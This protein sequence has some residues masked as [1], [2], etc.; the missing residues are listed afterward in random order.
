MLISYNWLKDYLG[1]DIPSVEEIT[2]LLTFH[3][4][5][6]DGVEDKGDDKVIDVKVLPDR[7]SDSLSHRGVAREIAT[8]IDESLVLDLFKDETELEITDKLVVNIEDGKDCQRFM[9]AYMEGVKVGPSPE[10]LRERLEALGQRSINNIVDST[11]YVMYSLGQPMHVYDADLFNKKDGQWN[12]SVRKAKEGETISLLPERPNTPNREIVLKGT[13]LLIVNGAENQPIGLAGVKGGIVAGLH[14]GTTNIILEAASFNSSLTRKTARSLNIVT[15]ASKRFENESPRI[16]PPYAIRMITKLIADIAGGTFKGVIDEYP[17]PQ[18]EIS[19]LVRKDRVNKVLGLVLEE[20]VIENILQRLGAT[21]EKVEEGWQVTAP[22]ERIDLVIEENYIDEI[23]RIHGLSQVKSILPE[24]L[25]VNEINTNYYYVNKIRNVLTEQGFSEVITSSFRKKD[26]IHLQNALASDKAYL[27]SSI[28]PSMQD[29]LTLNIQNV[30]VLGLRDIRIFEIGTVFNK[31]EGK[32]SEHAVLTLGARTK[33]TNQVPAD[34]KLVNEVLEALTLGGINVDASVEKG[35][36]EIN[37]TSLI[38]TL[39]TP[40]TYEETEKIPDLTYK[41]FS[42]YPAIVRDIAMWVP[43]DT[44]VD[45]ITKILE[46]NAG[47]LCVRVTLFDQ[48]TKEDRTSYAFRL[49]FQSFE[50]TLTDDG[51]QV[52]M[53]D[54]NNTVEKEGWEV[55]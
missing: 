8:L 3:A 21:I 55:R 36:C 32:V 39:D 54:V 31:E 12:F 10:W 43:A 19:V 28:I 16:L 53:E 52:C 38:S 17:L 33:K 30:D 41:P 18:T 2:E 40:A 37:L 51:V 42:S 46:E 5:E 34:D 9:L 49:V 15:D 22:L 25:P 13:E 4:F 29:S 7:G 45:K 44:E 35:V 24:L 48:F 47:P 27:R 23:G 14:E 1:E 6:I 11:N 20:P 26:E 50:K